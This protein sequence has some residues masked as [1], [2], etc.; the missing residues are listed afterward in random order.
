VSEKNRE[1]PTSRGGLQE[2]LKE[3]LELEVP[4]EPAGPGNSA[5]LEYVAHS[6]FDGRVPRKKARADC[7]E[8]GA[9]GE[10][11]ENPG[12]DAE[13]AGASDS[14]GGAEPVEITVAPPDCVV[15]ACRGGGK[16]FLGA[17]ATVLDLVYKHGI[18]IRILGGSLE[19]SR[20][21]HEHLR[22][23]FG[24]EWLAELVDGRIL[25]RRIRLKNGSQVELLAQSETSVRGVRVQKL[26][27]D[28][29][30]LFD[31]PV[32]AAAQLVTRSKRCGKYDVPGTIECLSTMHLPYGLMRDV[33]AEAQEGKRTL[34]RWGVMD[35]LEKCGNEHECESDEATC[36]L[37]IECGRKAKHKNWSGHV[38]VDDAISQKS[39]VS[40]ARWEAE[41]LCERPSTSHSVL[42]EFDVNAHVKEAPAD[43]R[44]WKYVGGMDFGHRALAVVLWAGVDP[45]GRLWILNERA[46][47]GK[48]LGDHIEAIGRTLPRLDWIGADPAGNQANG[49]TGKADIERMRQAGIRVRARGSRIR[50]GLEALRARLRPAG[51]GVRLF[52][53]AR[54]ETL[55]RS[56]ESYHYDESRP[57]CETPVKDGADHAVDALRYLVLNLDRPCTARRG[58]YAG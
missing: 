1:A 53:S 41:M 12:A 26:R 57:D 33:V 52:V 30:E 22:E 40:L 34:F 55:I 3:H 16:T 56:M 23:L 24:R 14:N 37:L 36:P 18:Q 27:C 58:V 29:V 4:G 49:Q 10:S 13:G 48:L 6:F 19:Q 8:P 17:V 21:M 45:E 51:G 54:C 5:P 28:E 39:R 35:V 42:P 11:V 7:V 50:E 32:W 9:D 44:G 46:Q 20:R 2:W 31:R 38:T 47:A 15:W 25:D 43:Q